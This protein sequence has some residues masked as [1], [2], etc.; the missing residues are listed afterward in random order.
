MGWLSEFCE[1][2][3]N[4]IGDTACGLVAELQHKKSSLMQ[5]RS[6]MDREFWD[7]LVS[8]KSRNGRTGQ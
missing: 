2:N 3:A 8:L 1:T 7:M 6:Q 4:R 5:Q